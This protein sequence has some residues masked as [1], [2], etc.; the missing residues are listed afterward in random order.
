[1]TYLYLFLSFFFLIS[2][3]C[4][5]N[6]GGGTRKPWLQDDN[7]Y[8]QVKQGQLIG[9]DAGDYLA[10]Y[11]IPFAKPP[12]DNLRWKKPEN[13]NGWS[14]VRNAIDISNVK[15]CPQ[16]EGGLNSPEGG[17]S[18]D[19]LYLNI[20]MPKPEIIEN[21]S[22]KKRPIMLWI[23]GGSYTSGSGALPG[24]NGGY[25][26]AYHGVIV[27]SINYRLGSFGFL[28]DQDIEKTNQEI[29]GNQGIYDM[30]KAMEWVR[31]NVDSFYG[32]RDK[33]TIFGQSAGGQAVTT[34]LSLKNDTN[35]NY[36]NYF[37]QA[38]A[39][40]PPLGL[41]YR[42][43]SEAT[44]EAKKLLEKLGCNQPNNDKNPEIK[45]W[46]C[47]RSKTWKEVLDA[48]NKVR[49]LI[50][51]DK[52]SSIIEPWTP[53]LDD[54][55]LD[56]HPYYSLIDGRSWNKKIMMGH[57]TGEGD[58]FVYAVGGVPLGKREYQLLMKKF[59]EKDN[60]YN[61]VL[62]QYPSPCGDFAPGCDARSALGRIASSYLFDCPIRRALGRRSLTIEPNNGVTYKYLFGQ[63]VY[64]IP[65]L[66]KLARE[67]C[68]RTSCHSADLPYIF[69]T[70]EDY[71][72]DFD[73]SE[74]RFVDKMQTYWAN[75]ALTGSPNIRESRIDEFPGKEIEEVPC[76][77]RYTSANTDDCK[78]WGS[79]Y[80]LKKCK[81]NSLTTGFEPVRAEPK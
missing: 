46:E 75:F 68:S 13:P 52:I 16:S 62:K 50:D 2:K 25:L 10:F 48:Q 12:V 57:T 67:A 79:S 73:D 22:L 8:M 21:S 5:N 80:I 36:H 49:G 66:P 24:Y 55:L 23:H 6:R 14:G 81:K 32:D 59:F 47:A 43:K 61:E 63:P 31:D 41:L 7:Y 34:L 74:E 4:Q 64:Q 40:S 71:N 15:G 9:K 26:A 33:I 76:W 58:I 60:I 38:I 18:E 51:A 45:K 35:L 27:I 3:A 17:V 28:Y 30:I 39:Q 77:Q 65:A 69:G 1:M 78:G 54:I 72:L 29:V 20:F 42:T 44:D 11:N 70:Y 19:C 53:V 56:K 37:N